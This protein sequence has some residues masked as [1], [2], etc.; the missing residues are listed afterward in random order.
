MSWSRAV[1]APALAQAITNHVA[2][3][4]SVFEKPPQT[5]NAP[6]IVLGRPVEVQYS[7]FALGVDQC[8][9]PVLCVG[10]A[11]GD[12]AVANLITLVRGSLT[13]ATLGGVVQSC[14]AEYE[15]NWRNVNV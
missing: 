1:A 3:Q 7:Y 5:L 4:A 2:G 10:P 8:S 9:F 15:R 6:A 14:T 12:D 11:D 13:D